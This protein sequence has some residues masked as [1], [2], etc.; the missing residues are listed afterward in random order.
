MTGIYFLL[1]TFPVIFISYLIVRAGAVVLMITGMEEKKARF[2]SLSAFSGPGFTTREAES[3]VNHP[4]RRRI[5]STLI[6]LG[7]S[8]IVTVIVTSTSSLVTSKTRHLHFVPLILIV[9]IALITVVG[10]NKGFIRGG[11]DPVE[12]KLS[13]R[14]TFDETD[15]EDLLHLG[16]GYGLVRVSIRPDSRWQ[17][18]PFSEF[19]SELRSALLLGI[20]RKG[21]WIAIPGPNETVAENDRLIIYGH[22]KTIESGLS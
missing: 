18:R 21:N 3:V 19:S 4:Q 13:K 7:N 5:A 1:P 12:K 9:G 11:E 14:E 6:I 22:L 8:G 16:A 2:Q 15:A 10:K 20:E 17:G